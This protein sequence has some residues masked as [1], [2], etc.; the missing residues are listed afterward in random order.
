VATI[1]ASQAVISGAFSLTSQAIQLG[2]APRILIKFT[3]AWEKGQIFIPNINW[4]LLIAVVLLVL[5]F[6]TSSNLASAYVMTT[7][8]D[9]VPRAMWQNLRQNKVLHKTVAMLN[10]R[11]EEVPYVPESE[12]I[13]VVKLP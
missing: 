3:F 9:G 4:L 1:I 8:R 10:V 12:R 13:E 11:G 2:Y 7:N 5:L 6:R